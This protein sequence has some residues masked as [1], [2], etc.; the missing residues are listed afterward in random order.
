MKSAKKILI[1]LGL[2]MCLSM[3]Y[4][5]KTQDFKPGR[6]CSFPQTYTNTEISRADSAHGFDVQKYEITLSINDA[7]HNVF[8]NVLAT[9]QATENLFQYSL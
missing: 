9:V 3:L 7:F 8:G 1:I 4:G 5:Q 2:I 6:K